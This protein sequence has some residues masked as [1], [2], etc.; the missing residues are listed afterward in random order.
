MQN[1]QN[2]VS[3][4]ISLIFRA[5]LIIVV[6]ATYFL[7][8]N[9]TSES[10]DMAKFLVLIVFVCLMLILTSSKFAI[11]NKVNFKRTPF[12]LPLLLLLVV[13]IVSTI[14]SH[15]P[16]VSLLGYNLRVHGSLASL[17]AYILFYFVLTQNLRTHTQVKTILN[18]SI[19][20]GAV[21]SLLSLASY[22]GI[23]TLPIT[24]TG[25]SFS[26]AAILAL[27]VPVVVSEILHYK[28][29]TFMVVN[30]FFLALFGVTLGLTGSLATWVAGGAG[31]LITFFVLNPS[32]LNL[33]SFSL[34]PQIAGI[35]TA[36]LVTGLA[37]G[38]SFVPPAGGMANP[39][40][41]ASKNF[42]REVT[43]DYLNS[44][45]ISV[46]AFRDSPFWGAGP[47]TYL[48]NF[49]TYKPVE[50]NTSKYWNIRF[51]SAFNEYFQVL[52]NFGGL[53]ILALLSITALF[54]TRVVSV[55]KSNPPTG[56]SLNVGLAVS[57]VGF[58]II[59]ALHASS[60]PFFVMG[61]LVLA[62]FWALNTG[63]GR[64]PFLSN[65]V[66]MSS[67][68]ISKVEALP[69][70]ILTVSIALVLFTGFFGG[71]IY[72]ADYH[73][74]NALKAVAQNNGVVAYNELIASEKL[75]PWSDLYR[76]DLA[77]VNFAL[78]NAIAL[79]KGPS[80][81]QPQ[82]SLTDQDKQNIQTLLQQS[83]TEGRT[84]VA[85]SPR[86]AINWEILALLYRQIAGVAQNALLFSL[87]SYGRAIFNDPLN[88]ALRLNVGGVYYAVK[89]YDQAIRFFTDA[90]N[91]KPD[92]ANGYYN[93]SVALR[94]K[95]DLTGAIQ[96]GEKVV[97]LVDKSSPDYKIATDYLADLKVKAGGPPTEPP[98]AGTTGALQEQ[99][100][101]KVINLPKPE[102]IATPEAIKK[103]SP[104]PS[105][106]P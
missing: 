16:F 71:K 31:V 1:L 106:Q 5:G 26:T 20:F 54:L 10:F 94:D 6:L 3:T 27:L 65:L 12:D 32:G 100:L 34:K 33:N 99:K 67:E 59:L 87:D 42:P 101:P 44:W 88:P 30:T 102:N 46:S 57:G 29:F 83:I 62:C 39:L 9:F 85:L 7:F 43:L 64:I 8:S 15:A 75:N 84:A 25:S 66:N 38:L 18:L 21:L 49:T 37:V 97:T 73:H 77:Q 70:I 50:F 91:L 17:I 96:A 51:D 4:Y 78:A 104:S 82:G 105:P 92:Y 19:L 72:L 76:T 56:G 93:L 11:E 52:A 60:L 98:A 95:G 35:I 47:S 81:T 90:I 61:L 45:K 14:F 68:Q 22:F 13:G 36:L 24:T 80:A 41:Q 89:S 55:F 74:K 69:S 63:E 103:P 48:F 86:S 40:Y 58:F 28:N 53:G 79:S 2:L 23:K